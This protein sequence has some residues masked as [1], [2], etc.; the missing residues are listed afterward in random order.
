MINSIGN[1]CFNAGPKK[2]IKADTGNPVGLLKHGLACDQFTRISFGSNNP[3]EIG[4]EVCRTH[5]TDRSTG[6][7][8]EVSITYER[9]K[10]KYNNK[11]HFDIY[12]MY[13]ISSELLGYMEI[14]REKGKYPGKGETIQSYIYL[15]VLDARPGNYPGTDKTS[16]K[17]NG[18]GSALLQ[19]AIEKSLK[20]KEC[21]GRVLT[22]AINLPDDFE[23]VNPTAFYKA[24]GFEKISNEFDEVAM[25]L[26]D[27]A[28]E[29]WK[30]TIGLKNSKT[31]S[32]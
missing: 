13:S 26:P 23:S 18:I 20:D 16:K 15:G 3:E 22:E 24:M 6:E 28:I 31:S 27:A 12:R 21:Q 25:Y 17:Y 4:V 11:H 9:N 2:L 30:N 8:K 7:K 10:G 14:D 1:F 32:I 29:H 5:I 19:L